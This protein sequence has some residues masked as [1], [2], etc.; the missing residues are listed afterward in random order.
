MEGRKEKEGEGLK[1]RSKGAPAPR[2]ILI[3]HISGRADREGIID[4]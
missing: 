3:Y 4:W 2:N 1:R